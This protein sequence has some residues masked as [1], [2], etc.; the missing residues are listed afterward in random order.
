MVGARV[1]G[2]GSVNESRQKDPAA[3]NHLDN[4]VHDWGWW[5]R[6][7]TRLL[8]RSRG[9]RLVS[10]PRALPSVETVSELSRHENGAFLWL[11]P[12]KSLHNLQ[13]PKVALGQHA[14]YVVD[15]YKREFAPREDRPL[16]AYFRNPLIYGRQ[17]SILDSRKH[18]FT[19]C[20]RRDRRWKAGVPRR[21]EEIEQKA[22]HVP[23]TYLQACAEAHYHYAHHFCDIVP[24]LM[25]YEQQ[26]LLHKIPALLHESGAPVISDESFHM[27]GLDTEDSKR[28]DDTCWKLDGLYFASEFKKFCSWTPE[29]AAWVRHKYSPGLDR[30][31]PGQK[32]FYISRRSVGRPALNEDEILAALKPWGITVVEPDRLSLRGQIDLFSEA[33]LIM[34]P[35]GAGIQ[36]ALWAP[37][38]CMILELISPRYFSG[39][40]WTLAE[41]LGHHYGLVTGA[42]DAKED[43]TRIG[44]TY[45]PQLINRA[46]EALACSR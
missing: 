2:N 42:T 13:P 25:L 8:I 22:R 18:A 9:Y 35:Q 24:R 29:S 15:Y 30:K 3:L 26:G 17:F 44:S 38:G 40:Y 37:R 28:W 4:L 46:V 5:N 32:L 34:G 12:R 20:I 14:D 31:P 1:Y 41:S 21:G 33:G 45:D 23:G 19:E 7:Y 36:N 27:L 43:P 11:E 16:I 10:M 39:V 6:A